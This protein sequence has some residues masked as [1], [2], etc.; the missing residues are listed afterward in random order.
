MTTE[1]IA[2]SIAEVPSVESEIAAEKQ[3]TTREVKGAKAATGTRKKGSTKA[4]AKAGKSTKTALAKPAAAKAKAKAK[5]ESKVKHVEIVEKAKKDKLVRD[6]FT[7]PATEYALLSELKKRC[8]TN[9]VA[10]KKSE[11]LRAALASLSAAS[12]ANVLKSIN[13]LNIIKTGRPAKAKA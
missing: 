10:V 6:S 11:V 3:A 5:L 9:G 2:P 7:M 8:L 1:K 4:T 13:K 12:D